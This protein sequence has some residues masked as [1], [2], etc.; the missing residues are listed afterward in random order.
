MRMFK[1]V[2]L[3]A[4]FL[5]AIFSCVAIVLGCSS[6][7]PP[8]HGGSASSQT[9][10]DANNNS[11]DLVDNSAK[12]KN[13]AAEPSDRS[14]DTSAAIA[15]T[16]PD[17]RVR[18][19][20]RANELQ[21]ANKLSESYDELKT[22]L[23]CDPADA[24][25]LF[26]MATL[27]NAMGETANAIELLGAVPADHP[28]AGL[29]ALGQSADW[30]MMLHRY[31]DAEARYEQILEQV[32]D[33]I[34]A[35]R[36]LAFLLNRQGRR[37]EASH[38]I[39]K[40]CLQGNV[41]QD[42]L[43][44]LIA[45]GDAMY[46]EPPPEQPSTD[47]PAK[48]QS[49]RN[50]YPIAPCGHARRAFHDLDFARVIELLKPVIDD[51]TAP[52][53]M[54]A[55]FGRAAA[56]N[57]D[58]AMLAFWFKS[59]TPEVTEFADY[60]ATLGVLDLMSQNYGSA[61]R[62]LGEALRRDP[63]D[64]ASVSRMRQALGS[65]DQ[66]DDAERWFD[67]W[68]K[69]RAALDAN[70][71]VAKNANPDPSAVEQLAAALEDLDRPLEAILWR[72]RIA[73]G[74]KG[75]HSMASLNEQRLA[76]LVKGNS[77]PDLS[78]NLCGLDLQQ[79]PLPDQSNIAS[80]NATQESDR[81]G[82]ANG[83]I[84]AAAFS[85]VASEIDLHHTYRVASVAQSTRFAI[86]QSLG[87]GVAVLDYDLDGLPDLYFAQGAADP[88][89]FKNNKPNQLYRNLSKHVADTTNLAGVRGSRYTLGVTA[90]DWNQDGFDDIA[91][92][93]IGSCLLLLNNGDGTYSERRVQ[94][95]PN[96]N[97]IPASIAIADATGDNLP[98]V[99]QL[100]YINDPNVSQKS[101]VDADGNVVTTIGPSKFA[102][103]IDHLFVNQGDGTFV[104]RGLSDKAS[105]RPGLGLVIA[106]FDGIGSGDDLSCNEIFIGNDT[107][108]NRLWKLKPIGHD[109]DDLA[110]A[111]G[112]AY[113]FSGGATGAMGIAVGDFDQ[114][115]K[116]DLHVTNYENENANL[117]MTK[118]RS[119]QD[120]NR[121]YKLGKS[122][123][124]LVGFGTQTIDHDNDGDEDLVVAN[125]HLDNAKSIRGTYAQPMQLFCNVGNEFRLSEVEDPSGF[126]ADSHVGRGLATLDFNRDG[127]TDVVVTQIERPSALLV[128][129]GKLGHHW[130]QIV[131]AGTT[132]ERDAIGAQ[133]EI[134]FGDRTS[135]V[136]NVGG[137]GYLC[138]NE[139]VC[140]F[141]LGQATQVDQLR[142]R[143]PHGQ[144]QTFDNPPI[145][146]RV[147][148]IESDPNLF[149]LD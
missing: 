7:A 108:P 113:G 28:D 138:R 16:A 104:F 53:A 75:E 117:F 69:L 128:N 112:C 30:C 40:L 136:W 37:H 139:Q 118:G 26:R 111:L 100:G 55:L 135:V 62:A 131:L 86:Y 105:A 129:E 124:L 43:H 47:T 17:N 94:Q 77:F 54:I 123:K 25:V 101:P 74:K 61:A 32:P 81:N 52:P 147:L 78:S 85:N 132:S 103:A 59:L 64:M 6:D 42:E 109:H 142:V 38:L 4:I 11:S 18:V 99:V 36:P 73:G 27:A 67:R 20:L 50:Y 35:L 115:Q 8:S 102:A 149:V 82:L 5:L 79:Y 41:T 141:G 21:E 31:D 57:Q 146:H 58:D 107:R 88:P 133:I 130:L 15:E 51:S 71:L 127:Q 110:T 39:R 90:G 119:F 10:T 72:A 148:A 93:S 65:L 137:D 76:L 63:T 14:N 3:L 83:Q 106:N 95:P 97:R 92:A 126:W 89:Q 23:I 34:P 122:S 84:F 145:D 125:G 120:R 45:I 68:T 121:Q 144:T 80:A 1:R 22:L 29:A 91:V 48:Q 9:S 24:E 98:D 116:I 13:S 46:T 66:E 140:S 60:W 33:A 2:D 44:S 70:N 87:G 134:Q 49:G 114:N 96:P 12:P 56:E 143:W 19:I